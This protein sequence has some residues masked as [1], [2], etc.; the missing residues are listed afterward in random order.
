[1]DANIQKISSIILYEDKTKTL[2]FQNALTLETLVLLSSS[3]PQVPDGNL[4][5]DFAKVCHLDTAGAWEIIR[6]K[7]HLESKGFSLT[8]QNLSKEKARLIV[9]MEKWQF[10]PSPLKIQ[11]SWYLNLLENTG[12]YVFSLFNTL[13]SMCNFMGIVFYYF[14]K[15][16]TTH[17]K[18]FP[19]FMSALDKCGIKAIP[20]I[21]L[22]SFL[23]GAVV[24]YEGAVQLARFGAKIVTIDLLSYSILREVGVLLTAVV[25]AGRSGSSFAAEI[26]TMKVNE[27]IEAMKV[28]GLNPVFILVLPRILALTLFLPLLTFISDIAGLMGGALVC[29]WEMDLSF[30][31]F[32]DHL[33]HIIKPSTFWVGIAKAPL[34]GFI[35]GIVSCLE[36]F[37]AHRN[38][39]SVGLRT[40]S[41]VVQS[42]FLV[43]VLNGFI[44]IF[45]SYLRI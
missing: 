13:K 33:K 24:A 41:S 2:Y 3:L 4:I 16:F 5:L 35:I 38:A 17:Q 20:I 39:E 37:K 8:F 45:L 34:F 26:G 22:I 44:S 40:T 42:I 29:Y 32:I 9:F 18:I 14:T 15:V 43:I 7:N 21:I 1:M 30:V 23:I 11:S 28:I 12:H 36:G 25:I 10:S 27:E 31:Y 19:N 6:L